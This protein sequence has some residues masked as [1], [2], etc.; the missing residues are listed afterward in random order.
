MIDH[1]CTATQK[2]VPSLPAEEKEPR[3]SKKTESKK[4]KQL[5]F[6]WPAIQE[7]FDIAH[8]FDGENDSYEEKKKQFQTVV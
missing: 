6:D 2:T 3:K 7:E 5:R 1:W 8:H 4:I